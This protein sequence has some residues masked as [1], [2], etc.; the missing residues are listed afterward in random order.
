MSPNATRTL[1]GDFQSLVQNLRTHELARIELEDLCGAV[2]R[3]L[4]Y[5]APDTASAYRSSL[6]RIK[7]LA[8][9]YQ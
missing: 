7:H 8:G 1:S 4:S 2:V 5:Y 3:A 9:E 6:E